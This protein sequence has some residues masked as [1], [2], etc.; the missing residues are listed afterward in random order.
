[1]PDRL[2]R[3]NSAAGEHLSSLKSLAKRVK[4]SSE[5]NLE[6]LN[7]G[8]TNEIFRAS[9]SLAGLANFIS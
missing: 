9:G 2:G 6:V 1:V 8:I 5:K 3:I 7:L 4:I